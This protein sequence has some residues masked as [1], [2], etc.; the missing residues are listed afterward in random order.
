MSITGFLFRILSIDKTCFPIKTKLADQKP[1]RSRAKEVIERSR[2]NYG[3]RQN[4]P[5]PSH[6]EPLI[7]QPPVVVAAS[8][9]DPSRIF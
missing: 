7:P 2:L 3:M 8:D 1:D 6:D 4:E 5:L 9:L